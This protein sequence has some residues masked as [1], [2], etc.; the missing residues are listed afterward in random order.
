MLL[1]RRLLRNLLSRRL[2]SGLRTVAPETKRGR[3]PILLRLLS[4]GTSAVLPKRAA[5]ILAKCT[6]GIGTVGILQ[7][8]TAACRAAGLL[9][10]PQIKVELPQRILR[11]IVHRL[12]ALA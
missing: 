11:L 12:D 4:E 10:F 3:L 2:R 8:A 9:L 7:T 6:A 5:V 1:Q